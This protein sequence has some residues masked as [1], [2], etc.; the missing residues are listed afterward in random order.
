MRP[1]RDYYKL[2]GVSWRSSDSE[3]KAAFYRLAKRFHPD[4]G[5]VRDTG[6]GTV[7]KFREVNEAYQAL[8][9]NRTWYDHLY[10]QQK[11]K[12]DQTDST[13]STSSFASEGWGFYYC[14]QSTF[15]SPS[16]DRWGRVHRVVRAAATARETV[17]APRAVHTAQSRQGWEVPPG[18]DGTTSRRRSSKQ[19][20][21]NGRNGEEK[22]GKPV[23]D[24]TDF[25]R[26]R[27][28]WKYEW[29]IEDDFMKQY[30]KNKYREQYDD[31][32]TSREQRYENTCKKGQQEKKYFNQKLH[33]NPKNDYQKKDGSHGTYNK[34]KQVG[35]IYGRYVLS[36][37]T[38]GSSHSRSS[39]KK[40]PTKTST[41]R[42]DNNNG[43]TKPSSKEYLHIKNLKDIAEQLQEKLDKTNNKKT[44]SSNIPTNRTTAR[45]NTVV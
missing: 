14:P 28:P 39:S 12:R 34:A 3:I 4:V 17:R 23:G 26:H 1:F 10:N 9:K 18:E 13:D 11:I 25:K 43:G 6:G 40:H 30:R 22:K 15:S 8:S 41:N 5:D 29:E 37:E 36:F 31:S 7:E 24:H 32:T 45:D 27:R 16:S 33:N 44:S 42:S 21:R 19:E 2:L 20:E 38:A 35:S